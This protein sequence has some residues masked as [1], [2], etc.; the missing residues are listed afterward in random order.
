MALGTSL[1]RDP[2]YFP[3]STDIHGQQRLPSPDALPKPADPKVLS[4]TQFLQER[5]EGRAV[6]K[7]QTMKKLGQPRVI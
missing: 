2:L 1:Q 4:S 3:M 5:D 7:H 6:P